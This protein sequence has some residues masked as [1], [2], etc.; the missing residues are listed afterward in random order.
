MSQTYGEP[1]RPV[2]EVAEYYKTLCHRPLRG[3]YCDVEIVVSI[4]TSDPNP[5]HTSIILFFLG[6]L[7]RRNPSSLHNKPF[8]LVIR[9]NV[10]SDKLGMYCAFCHNATFNPWAN[11]KITDWSCYVPRIPKTLQPFHFLPKT[12]HLTVDNVLSIQCYC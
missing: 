7:K 12:G 2:S 5:F 10:C 11:E 6:T 9:S 1:I 8:V 3:R 4:I